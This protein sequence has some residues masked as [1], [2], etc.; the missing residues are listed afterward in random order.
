VARARNTTMSAVALAWLRADET[1][2]ARMSGRCSRKE[3][4][5]IEALLFVVLDHAFEDFDRG[6][7]RGAILHRLGECRAAPPL[8]MLPEV[9]ANHAFRA[10]KK[11]LVDSSP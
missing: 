8:L 10:V 4:E 2:P 5:L 6:G 7:D 9:R 3:P 11:G 1:I